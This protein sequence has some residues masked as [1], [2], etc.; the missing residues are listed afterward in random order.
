MHTHVHRCVHTMHRLTHQTPCTHS[1]FLGRLTPWLAPCICVFRH[2]QPKEG[3][4]LREPGWELGLGEQARG[5]GKV[6]DTRLGGQGGDSG[7]GVGGGRGEREEGRGELGVLQK[8]GAPASAPLPSS[9]S[10]LLAPSFQHTGCSHGYPSCRVLKGAYH[11]LPLKFSHLYCTGA[12]TT[13]KEMK[14]LN[15]ER[16]QQCGEPLCVCLA[17]QRAVCGAGGGPQEGDAAGPPV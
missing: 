13:A 10:S 9:P 17:K 7:R 16:K 3:R 12:L 8:R 11:L 14:G 2:L 1:P 6:L 15:P 5:S 4:G